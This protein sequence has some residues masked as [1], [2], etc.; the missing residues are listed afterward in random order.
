M[1]IFVKWKHFTYF[2][3]QFLSI[4]DGKLCQIEWKIKEV[5]CQIMEFP[6]ENFVKS[7]QAILGGSWEIC[8]IML[9]KNG[10]S[11]LCNLTKKKL[12]TFSKIFVNIYLY[13]ILSTLQEVSKD[14]QKKSFKNLKKTLDKLPQVC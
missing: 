12:L 3:Y 14:F 13:L 5:P 4:F 2:S 1:E 9:H 6:V 11:N 7:A 8:R 10:G